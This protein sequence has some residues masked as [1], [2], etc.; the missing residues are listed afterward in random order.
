MS[1]L[2]G[3]LDPWVSPITGKMRSVGS[4]PTLQ[5]DYILI[6]DKNNTAQP[7]LA[8]KDLRLDF[9]KLKENLAKATPIL[10]TPSKPFDKGQALNAL[11][12]GIMKQKDGIV[13]TAIP[14]ED[15]ATKETLEQIRDETKGYRDES[16]NY[17]DQALTS[18]SHAADS[19]DSASHAATAASVSSTLAS[20]SA[21]EASASA[22]LATTS[23]ATATTAAA[24]A[25]GFATAAGTAAGIASTASEDARQ[26]RDE[27]E[28]FK[29]QAQGFS[30]DSQNS[31]TASYNYLQQL[32][33]TGITF[34]GDVTGGGGL[35]SPIGLTLQLA[36]NQIRSPTADIDIDD[37]KIVNVKDPEN[38]LDVVNYRTLQNYVGG[39]ANLTLVGDGTA[40]GPLSGPI[41]FTLTKTLNAIGNAGDVNINN[42]RLTNVN[43]P[44]AAKDA[45]N[46]QY[47]DNH[48]WTASQITDFNSAVQSNS[49]SSLAPA[50]S[51]LNVNGHKIINQADPTDP[52]DGA[53]KEYVDS[54]V[55]TA[56]GNITLD[57]F[58]VGGPPVDG[59]IHTERGPTCLL[60]NIPAGG[61]V[62]MDN[63][64]I[65]NLQ[66]SPDEDFDAISMTFLWD[67]LHDR[68]EVTWP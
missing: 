10:Q 3:Y 24:T 59:V 45:A 30:V 7:S 12:P 56:I 43:D 63:Y 2:P 51:D 47:V 17:R 57:Q 60:T 32:L 35:S 55:S 66:Q 1:D 68:V 50:T 9:I 33:G 37:F 58:V 5:K 34:T 4:L 20:V 38:P 6:G 16:K 8:F 39:A 44:T 49:V 42:F 29:N 23:A 53:N 26:Y 13:A 36:L 21:T 28:T 27:A 22:A 14:D 54:A 61:D 64:R 18:E 62:S 19:A 15:Y 67:I 48:T 52:T 25:T 41:T 31:A 65:K 46:M 11:T 40:S